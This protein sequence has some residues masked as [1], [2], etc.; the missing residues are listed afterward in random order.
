M[1]SGY[2]TG[3]CATAAAKAA[4]IGLWKGKIPD[5]VEIDTRIIWG[6]CMIK[7][8]RGAFPFIAN[9]LKFILVNLFFLVM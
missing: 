8:E 9:R 1:R 4:A 7:V 6:T 5:E 3:S 2:T